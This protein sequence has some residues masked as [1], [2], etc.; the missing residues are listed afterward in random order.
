[1]P[2]TKSYRQLHERVVAPV[3]CPRGGSQGFGSEPWLRWRSTSSNRLSGNHP[4]QDRTTEG[5]LAGVDIGR[6]FG[7]IAPLQDRAGSSPMVTERAG[8]SWSESDSLLQ[9]STR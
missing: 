4:K 7:V 3:W 6:G 9:T 1:M 5:R 2:S 8:C